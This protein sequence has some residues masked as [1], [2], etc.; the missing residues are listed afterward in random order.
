MA[1]WWSPDINDDTRN[2]RDATASAAG[3]LILR[4]FAS[5]P[6]RSLSTER[7]SARSRIFWCEPRRDAAWLST[8]LRMLES[9][10]DMAASQLELRRLAQGNYQDRGLRL[11]FFRAQGRNP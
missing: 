9:L 11:R 5:V 3:G 2:S 8:E 1:R 10:A 6:V 7:Y 4:S